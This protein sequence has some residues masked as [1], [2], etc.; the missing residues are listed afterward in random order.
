MKEFKNENRNRYYGIR[1]GD[2][3]KCKYTFNQDT[4]YKVVHL[5]A[6]DNNRVYLQED[7]KEPFEAVA[8]H[9]EIVKM[10]E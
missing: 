6:L 10:V 8:E 5:S 9:C 3:V 1:V 4:I 7:G 2:L